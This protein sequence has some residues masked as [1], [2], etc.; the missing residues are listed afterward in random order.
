MR[1]HG[2]REIEERRL[3]HGT[4]NQNVD[5]ICKFNFDLR[6]AGQHAHVYGKGKWNDTVTNIAS[7]VGF[8][9]S[10]EFH[11]ISVF[12]FKEYILR[13]TPR[14]QTIT[15]EAVRIRCICMAEK[16]EG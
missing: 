1:I 2:I 7:N 4:A 6:I 11:L 8:V 10:P 16:H 3:F 12:F 13:D 5:S 15:A 9:C 14:T